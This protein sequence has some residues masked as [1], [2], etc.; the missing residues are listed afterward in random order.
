MLAIFVDLL[1]LV[2]VDL[3]LVAFVLLLLLVDLVREDVDE[4]KSQ[5]NLFCFPTVHVCLVSE[6]L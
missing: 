4:H 5:A 1:L 2:V 3:L 6:I